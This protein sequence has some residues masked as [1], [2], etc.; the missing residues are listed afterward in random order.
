MRQA[1][2]RQSVGNVS[3]TADSHLVKHGEE[4]EECDRV[5]V[6]LPLVGSAGI[7]TKCKKRRPRTAFTTIVTFLRY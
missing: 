7:S 5:W 2:R 4:C 3:H 6:A 1:S